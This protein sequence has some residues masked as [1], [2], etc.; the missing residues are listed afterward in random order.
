VP[1]TLDRQHMIATDPELTQTLV[2]NSPDALIA[3]SVEGNIL[4]WNPGAQNIFGY[5]REEAM[6]RSIVDLVVP[7]GRLD[8]TQQAIAETLEAGFKVYESVRR[9]KDGSLVDVAVSK[10]LVKDE[11][12]NV[13]F[14]AV[15]KKDITL[16]KVMRD[17]RLIEARFRGVLESVP[18]AIVIANKEGRILL[19]NSQS[20]KLFGYKRDE[21]QGQTIEMLLPARYKA[22]HVGHRTGYFEEPRARSMGAGLEL[23][24]LRCDGTEFPVEISL[25]PLETEVGTFAMSAIR[26]ITDRKKAEAKFRGLLEWAPDAMVIVNR[27]GVIVLINAQAEKLFGYSREELLGRPVEVLIP[28]EFRGGHVGTRSGY[29]TEP[30]VRPMGAGRDLTAERKNGSTFPAEISL[31]PLETEEGTLVMAAVRDITESRKAQEEIRR[32]NLELEEQNRRVQEATRMKSEFLANMSHEL[33]TPLN[34]IIGF[35]EFLIDQKPGPLNPKQSEYLGDILSSGR[36]LLRLIND[37]LDLAKV[38]AGKMDLTPEEFSV[39]D[40]IAEVCA[41]IAPSAGKKNISIEKH[42]APEVETVVLDQQRFKQVLFNLL[43]NA[44]KFTPESGRVWISTSSDEDG[45]FQVQVKDSGIGIRKE[46]IGRLF[47][48]FE[49]LDS[50]PGR[51]Y[52]GTGLGL[53]LTKKI[54]ELQQGSIQ[55][56]SEFGK[57]SAFSVALPTGLGR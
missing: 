7:D 5:T 31:S 33:R 9:R 49:Q 47:T 16:L 30:G 41:V 8:E 27:E 12:G 37:V 6:G 21:L 36:H 24:G 39:K 20:E 22:G 25:S 56:E 15:S 18:D 10:K 48:E 55:L 43:S 4:F 28:E 42:L 32:K 57:G 34:G 51:R 3:I 35:S 26:D 45:G 2:E 1:E 44:V 23:Y 50:S 11:H 46:D 40:A 19:V 17:A 13:R 29:I 52:E 54:V 14:I 53:A 38:E